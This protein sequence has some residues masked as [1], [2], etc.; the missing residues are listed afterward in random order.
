MAFILKSN[1]FKDDEK[2]PSK[3]S[4]KQGNL[5][6]P[7]FWKNA[8]SETKS[9]AFIMDDLKGPLRSIY[10][11][12]H[13]VLYNIPSHMNMLEEGISNKK[14]D[15]HD[16]CQINNI[17]RKCEYCGPAPPIGTHLYRFKIYALD[18]IFE[19]NSIKSRSKLIKE[20]KYHIID[21]A[22]LCGHYSS[23]SR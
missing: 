3:Y 16:I 14:L 8:P 19:P 2:I 11:I 9:F 17:F 22:E 15:E 6:P 23:K 13:W 5:S 4:M 21:T 7:I 10:T 18:T 12:P 20:M 1:V